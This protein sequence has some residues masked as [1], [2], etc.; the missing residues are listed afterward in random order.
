MIWI[1]SCAAAHIACTA[2][3]ER[4]AHIEGPKGIHI[5]EPGGLLCVDGGNGQRGF[6]QHI[7]QSL[8][9]IQGGEQGNVILGGYLADLDAVAGAVAG[10]PG[11]DDIGDVALTQG[12]GDLLAAGA[13]L[14]QRMG[15]DAVAFRNWAVPWVASMLKPSW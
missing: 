3:I 6:F 14:V 4:A 1:P 13:D 7:Q 9:G 15:A 8:H 5:D 12:V 2:H 10:V 11:V